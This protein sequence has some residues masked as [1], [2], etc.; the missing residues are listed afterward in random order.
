M[1]AVRAAIRTAEQ[2]DPDDKI[3]RH[4]D[5]WNVLDESGVPKLQALGKRLKDLYDARLKADYHLIP[6]NLKWAKDLADPRFARANAEVAQDIIGR[7]PQYDLT[8]VLGKLP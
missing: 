2:R 6:P 4:G 1:L 5:L 7:L 8:P 3:E